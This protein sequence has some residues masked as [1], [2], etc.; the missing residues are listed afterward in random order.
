V[1]VHSIAVPGDHDREIGLVH[2]GREGVT[3]DS[4]GPAAATGVSPSFPSAGDGRRHS[5]GRR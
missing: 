4:C 1:S 2:G 5:A 3:A